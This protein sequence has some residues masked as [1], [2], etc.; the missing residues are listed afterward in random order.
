M[1]WSYEQQL[2]TDQPLVKE[3]GQEAKEHVVQTQALAVV[4]QHGQGSQYHVLQAR[5]L[6]A[7]AQLLRQP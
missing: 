6:A 5:A 7:H 3:H 4:H 2:L 1:A